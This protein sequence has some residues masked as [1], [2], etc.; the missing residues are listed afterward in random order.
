MGRRRASTAPW[1]PVTSFGRLWRRGWAPRRDE[2]SELPREIRPRR[3]P[4]PRATAAESA[5]A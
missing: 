3:V 2:H 5:A 1:A 4:E